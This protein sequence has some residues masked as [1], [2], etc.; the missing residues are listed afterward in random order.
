MKK[1]LSAL[2]IL[3]LAAALL[4][5]YQWRR[6]ADR[7]TL[8]ARGGVYRSLGLKLELAPARGGVQGMLRLKPYVEIPQ[9]VLD[10]S[11]WGLAGPVALGSARLSANLW[12]PKGLLLVLEPGGV[13]RDGF[14]AKRLAFE[15][16][17]PDL[18]LGI[19]AESFALRN[20]ASGE[21]L[22]L[23]EPW[24]QVGTQT[25]PIPVQLN[26]RVEGLRY[27]NAKAA[28]PQDF[29]LGP[30][31]TGYNSEV[32]GGDRLWNFFHRGQ[33]GG[34]Q[35]SKGQGEIQPWSYTAKGSFAEIP[36]ERW[37]QLYQE[38]RGAV[39]SRPSVESMPA[40]ALLSS[41][42]ALIK[43]SMV[44]VL[45]LRP[46]PERIEF[47]WGGL[48]VGDAAKKPI[49]V[50]EPVEFQVNY[51]DLP[52]G[53][54]MEATGGIKKFS[55][56]IEDNRFEL[57]DLTLSQ[58]SF[59]RGLRY[60]DWLGYFLRYYAETMELQADPSRVL[61]RLNNLYLAYLAQMSDEMS[62]DFRLKLLKFQNPSYQTEH[63][64]AAILFTADA[65]AWNF[66][67]QDGFDSVPLG[68]ADKTIR[69]GKIDMTFGFKLPWSEL[70]SLA[71]SAQATPE[72]LPSLLSVVSGKPLG[73]DWKWVLD[74]GPE[75][76]A[77]QID[78]AMEADAAKIAGATPLSWNA[79]NMKLAGEKIAQDMLRAFLAQGKLDFRIQ[80]DRLSKLQAS[81]DKAYSGASLGLAVLGPYVEV[82]AKSDSMKAKLNLQNGE[83]LL[84][85][86]KSPE[87]EALLRKSFP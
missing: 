28:G 29:H 49:A 37:K 73:L 12:H 58:K 43:K 39:E 71:R 50:L 16:D 44:L 42:D 1:A 74:F 54:R 19:R 13:E 2:L 18:I 31:E 80:I 32:K 9:V 40:Q 60:Q 81:L 48:K 46:F 8:A 82:D 59:H 69:Q 85:G 26:F 22:S 36:W 25:G 4:I 14:E 87:I 30:M 10:L 56:D 72:S 24:L 84:N 35:F 66:R 15:L 23:Q 68:Q 53:L 3:I 17:M 47:R 57:V 75:L 6:T 67:L 21:T 65:G 83:V 11:G 77:L 38:W 70:L 62:G 76:F 51:S 61:E 55:M 34:F 86:R 63:R 33:G 41:F 20:Q 52:E 79:E 64:D 45:E 78:L 7:L 5:A 27:A